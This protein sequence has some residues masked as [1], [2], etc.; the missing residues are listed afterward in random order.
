M[1][2]ND[3]AAVSTVIPTDI[4]TI[5]NEMY[6]HVMVCE[7]IGNVHWTEVHRSTDNGEIW[8][9]TGATWPGDHHGGLFQML[10]WAQGDDGYVYAFS[11]GFQRDKGLILQRVFADRVTDPD[12]WEGWGLRD[13][14][15]ACGPEG[16]DFSVEF[17]HS[18][19][20]STLVAYHPFTYST[21][22]AD[23]LV[24]FV[25]IDFEN[26]SDIFVEINNT[27]LK[28]S[29]TPPVFSSGWRHVALTYTFFS[30]SP[31]SRCVESA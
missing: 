11:T 12:A 29:A 16:G 8:N 9:H 18:I 23:P 13:N 25:D 17:W 28:A 22:T 3:C 31:S 27:V 15:W 2:R 4:I 21:D 20:S 10:T 7:G 14:V 1:P 19:P 6:L 30:R 5:G 24:R 26:D